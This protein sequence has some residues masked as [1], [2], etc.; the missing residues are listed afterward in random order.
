M[1]SSSVYFFYLFLISSA[2]TRSLPFLSFIVPIFG[3][4]ILLIFP[5]FLKISL[6]FP[7]LLFSSSF[8]L[9]SLKK[10]FLSLHA[11]LWKSEFSWICLFLSPLLFASLISLAIRPPQITPVTSCFFFFLIWYGF[12]LCL[13]YNITDFHPQF[14]K[15]TVYKF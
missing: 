10:A 1:Y 4:N 14:F 12:V 5:V 15:H 3:Q 7:L 8:M 2:S 13:L 9:C 6:I 11:I